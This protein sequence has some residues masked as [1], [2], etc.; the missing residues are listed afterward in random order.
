MRAGADPQGALS[1]VSRDEL[2]V[3]ADGVMAR[4]RA[5]RHCAVLFW[6]TTFMAR[7]AKVLQKRRSRGKPT[8]TVRLPRTV[9]DRVKI[10]SGRQREPLSRSKAVCS[11]IELGL[12]GAH[13]ARPINKK[14]AAKASR[15]AG[16]MIDI[17]NDESAPPDVREKRKRRLL[18]GPPEFRA[19]RGDLP[20]SKG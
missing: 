5:A 10:W 9:L 1:V 8:V 11:L 7:R 17:L 13:I 14:A 12:T 4:W 16:Q 18:K 19:M 3:V 2:R 6:R 15:L 20:K